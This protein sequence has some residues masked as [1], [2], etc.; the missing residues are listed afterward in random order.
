MARRPSK[1]VPREFFTHSELM[2]TALVQVL[3]DVVNG[4]EPA[5]IA[6]FCDA[7]G[8]EHTWSLYRPMGAVG[9]LVLLADRTSTHR[10]VDVQPLDGL[11][12]Q[13]EPYA[14]DYIAQSE[15]LDT[16][17]RARHSAFERQ[18]AALEPRRQTA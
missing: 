18:R 6:R 13:I 2:R 11:R 1:T 9:G 17:T 12:A 10:W 5:A 14:R 3:A 7:D 4:I 8:D 15:A 16:L